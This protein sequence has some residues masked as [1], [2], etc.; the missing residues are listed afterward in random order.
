MVYGIRAVANLNKEVF[1][2]ILKEHIP[3][4]MR[5]LSLPVEPHAA[6]A[7]VKYI[8]VNLNIDRSMKLDSR[9]L[10]AVVCLLVV[11]MVDFITV[12]LGEYAP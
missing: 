1:R 8:V 3:V 5:A 10:S 12:N 2:K 11:N 7:A 6:V 4:K 9:H